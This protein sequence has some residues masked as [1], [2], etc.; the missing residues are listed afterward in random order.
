MSN[1]SVIGI[2]LG[3]TNLK[4]GTCKAGEVS[5]CKTYHYD[6]NAS[7][8][9]IIDFIG[10]CILEQKSWGN[11]SGIGIGVPSIVDIEQG[12]VF[13]AVNIPSWQEVHLKY[14]LETRFAV[15]VHINNDINCFVAGEKYFGHGQDIKNLVGMCLGTGLGAGLFTNDQLYCGANCGAGEIGE[16]EYLD[17]NFEAYVSGQFFKNQFNQTGKQL[18]QLALQGDQQAIFAFEQFGFH[19]GKVMAVAALA[20]DPQMIVLGGSVTDA[21]NLFLPKTKQVISEL[22]FANIREKLQIQVS[23]DADIAVKGAAALFF[24]SLSE[25]FDS[26]VTCSEE[27]MG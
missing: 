4:I 13:D 19:L 10:E 1:F 20:Y 17:S 5:D 11:V 6:A 16:I 18:Y 24:N 21:A 12:I 27:K 26:F 7:K 25:E 9:D 14:E 15:P 2:D 22:P 8:M 23:T 3:G